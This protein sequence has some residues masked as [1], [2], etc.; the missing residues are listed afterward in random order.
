MR[1]AYNAGKSS[2]WESFKEEFRETCKLS[3]WTFDR[4]Q[5]AYDKVALVDV[6]SLSIAQDISRKS[7]DFLRRII[8]PVDGM[9]VCPVVRL[10]ALQLLPFGG[11]HVVGI[12][13]TPTRQQ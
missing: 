5:E 2:N 9:G 11:L 10:P 7:T 12:D 1:R 6:G 13:G 4:L 3:E 8:A